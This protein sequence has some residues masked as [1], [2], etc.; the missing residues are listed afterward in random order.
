MIDCNMIS[1]VQLG[2]VQRIEQLNRNR[3]DTESSIILARGNIHPETYELKEKTEP[4]KEKKKK[5]KQSP[6]SLMMHFFQ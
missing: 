6:I 5:E 3:I 4:K 2:R 1:E